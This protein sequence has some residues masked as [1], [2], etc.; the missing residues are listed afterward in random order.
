MCT[1]HAPEIYKVDI[2]VSRTLV[3]LYWI[4]S[5]LSFDLGLSYNKMAIRAI[6]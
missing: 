4:I 5:V 2:P 6:K 1:D 3:L